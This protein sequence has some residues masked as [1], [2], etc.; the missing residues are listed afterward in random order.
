MEENGIIVGRGF[1][2]PKFDE[3]QFANVTVIYE[4]GIFV[5]YRSF[6][7]VC[8]IVEGRADNAA[9]DRATAPTF[10]QNEPWFRKQVDYMFR[11]AEHIGE[12]LACQETLLASAK[13]SAIHPMFVMDR[14]TLSPAEL[15]DRLKGKAQVRFRLA[16]DYSAEKWSVGKVESIDVIT[17]KNVDSNQ[18]YSLVTLPGALIEGDRIS[19]FQ[20]GGDGHPLGDLMHLVLGAMG[21]NCNIDQKF[22]AHDSYSN[23]RDMIITISRA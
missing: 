5:G 15:I 20:A 2:V 8:G 6:G 11:I 14:S 19:K 18:V 12:V 7:T 17:G 9:R 22:V 4:R 23:K 21:E 13:Y 10:T 3:T 1:L 16:Q